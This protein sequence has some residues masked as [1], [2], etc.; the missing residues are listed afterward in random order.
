MEGIAGMEFEELT[1]LAGVT[2]F[3]W[4]AFPAGI[5]GEGSGEARKEFVFSLYGTQMWSR[6]TIMESVSSLSAGS[7]SDTDFGIPENRQNLS[8]MVVS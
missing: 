7:E 1:E 5:R 4:E 3:D 2:F 6:G 8:Y